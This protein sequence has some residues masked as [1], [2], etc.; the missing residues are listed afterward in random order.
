MKVGSIISYRTQVQTKNTEKSAIN[1]INLAKTNVIQISFGGIKNINQFVSYTPE[2]NGLGLPE[3]SQGGEGVV[4]YELPESLIKHEKKDV[5]SFMP[6]WEHD[7]AKGGYKFLI[8]RGK[9]E[10]QM[11]AKAFYSANPGED[12]EAVAKKLKLSTDDLSYVIQSR[13][14]GNGPDALSKYCLLEPTSIKG[15]VKRPSSHN[16]G[17]LEKIPYALF[18]I[19]DKNP[20]YNKLKGQNHYFIY[21]P[22]LA[23]ASK[24]YAYDTSGHVPFAAEIINSD[25]TR[26]LEQIIKSKMNTKEFGYFNPASVICHDRPSAAFVVHLANSSSNGDTNTLGMKAHVIQHNPSRNYQGLTSNPFEYFQIIASEQDVKDL[27]THPDFPTILKAQQ[28]GID[29]E[30][31][32]PLEKQIVH[33]VLDPYLDRFKDGSGTYN[34]I[35]SSILGAKYNPEHLST[36]T[37]SY[38]FAKEMKSLK[39]PD[40]AKFLTGDFADIETK[41]V[42]NGSTPASLRLDDPNADF[43]RGNN[44]LSKEKAGFTTFKYDGTNIEEVVDA[45]KK[46]GIWLTDLIEKAGKKGQKELNKLFFNEGQ[47]IDGHNV[48]GYVSKMGPDDIL[49]MGW[50]RADEQKGYNM[51]FDGFLQFLKR[52][53]IPKKLKQRVKLIVGAGPWDKNAKDYLSVKRALEEIQK[54]DG[55]IYK[56]NAMYVDGYY[57]NRLVGCATY[58]IFTSRREMCGITPL[59]SKAAGVPYG[60]TKTGGPVDYTNPSNGYLTKHAVELDPKEYGLSWESGADAID[61]ARCARQSDQISDIL[62]EMVYEYSNNRESY[63]AKC[64]KNIEEKFDWHNNHE[65]NFG[66]SANKRY[67]Y[68]I[69]ETDKGFEARS[70]TF[71]QRIQGKFG[72]YQAQVEEA[73]AKTK[74]KPAKAALFIAGGVLAIGAGITVYFLNKAP[75]KKNLA[76]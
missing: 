42:L 29:S 3:T 37:V 68:G 7:N 45:R 66:Q 40:A 76:A 24:P 36:G 10:D 25:S 12:I 67:M 75:K 8:H 51:T 1:P 33:S 5:R 18:R 2:N 54:L 59:E 6:F 61:D 16:I 62:K 19:S 70:K 73:I 74:F 47:I 4:A 53:D 30:H 46:N 39:T 50:G 48:M 20:S 57:P 58:G 65:Y 71:M 17:E 32:T 26:A 23:K 15:V 63:I 52:D 31:L 14:N 34:V 28:Y 49:V 38:T 41:D 35:K 21:T 55:G 27:S 60:A 9:L 72:Y 69:F 22:E 11:P 43:G 44:G 56:N 13:P 64:K